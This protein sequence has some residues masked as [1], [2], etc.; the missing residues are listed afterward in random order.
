MTKLDSEKL[1]SVLVPVEVYFSRVACTDAVSPA[2]QAKV[3]DTESTGSA[4]CP[5]PG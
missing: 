2:G 5:V 1:E 4:S 3:N